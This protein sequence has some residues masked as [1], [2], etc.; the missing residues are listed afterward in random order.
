[1][2]EVLLDYGDGKM[3]VEL[4]GHAT[5][6]RYGKT[7]KDP[8]PLGD[9]IELT[10]AALQ[11]PLDTP[12]LRAMA[13]PGKKVVIGFPD[14]VKGGAHPKAHRR[15]A[16]KAV[17]E[18][19][20]AGGCDLENISLLCGMGLHRQNTLEEF[21]WYLGADIVD[22]FHPGR[23]VNHDGEAPNLADFGTDAMGNRVQCNRS[24]VDADLVV[25][26]GHCSSPASRAGSPSPRTTR[27]R[28]CTATTGSAGRSTSTC[29][30]SS[31]PSA[32][33]WNRA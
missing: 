24:L 15:V 11:K 19:L 13:G 8:E 27:R 12:P 17:V 5:V 21:Y 7:Y 3:R 16:I 29:A 30:T 1:M 28:P 22:Q 23:L 9:S 6:V 26:I 14:R 31:S 33:P 32:R 25:M 18:E 10:R 2:Q 20:L 4:P